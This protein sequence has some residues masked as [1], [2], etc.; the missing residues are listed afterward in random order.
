MTKGSRAVAS[1]LQ[2]QQESSLKWIKHGDQ[3]NFTSLSYF[4]LTNLFSI[5]M[6]CEIF[7]NKLW[8]SL[9]HYYVM[10]VKL[11]LTLSNLK[12]GLVELAALMFTI[13]K[14]TIRAHFNIFCKKSALL[15][16]LISIITLF[17]LFKFT[18]IS[19][20]L[21]LFLSIY[22]LLSAVSLHFQFSI[23]NFNMIL[24][25]FC[26]IHNTWNNIIF[27]NFLHT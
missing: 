4:T 2:L 22:E 17:L 6:M 23:F 25:R 7:M 16:F 14:F 10:C 15:L 18:F 19:F 21:F 26:K 20:F 12:S 1:R 24:N 27:L 5:Y 13:T 11:T 8:I 9:V 3:V